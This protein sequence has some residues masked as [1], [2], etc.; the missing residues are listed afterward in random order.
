MLASPV[1]VPA[2]PTLIALPAASVI[3]AVPAAPFSA[4]SV[5]VWPGAVS[6]A[7]HGRGAE[8]NHAADMRWRRRVQQPDP[9]G[10][11]VGDRALHREPG[12][13]GVGVR[14]V[15]HVK[16]ACG[17][18]RAEHVEVVRRRH[19]G[20]SR[21]R[22]A[23]L[24]QRADQRDRA[25]RAAGYR[26]DLHRSARARPGAADADPA[27]GRLGDVALRIQ[28]ERRRRVGQRDRPRDRQGAGRGDGPVEA[29]EP[30]RLR[31]GRADIGRRAQRVDERQ[32]RRDPPMSRHRPPSRSARR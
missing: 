6:V 9:A 21:R 32:L 15:G 1:R 7:A 28:A 23:G 11:R 4:T 14:R 27:P 13:P 20:R 25:A 22:E 24:A 17:R 18:E 8:R 30:D 12:Q 5:T 31:T 16:P 2:L 10:A 19:R 3:A 29:A 26:A